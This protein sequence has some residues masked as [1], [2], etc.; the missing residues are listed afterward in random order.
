MT[1][2][3]EKQAELILDGLYSEEEKKAALIAEKEQLLRAINEAV[4]SLLPSQK[5]SIEGKI[6]AG[7]FL[8]LIH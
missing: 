5:K 2:S 8:F 6:F 3:L 1:T 4:E 7:Y